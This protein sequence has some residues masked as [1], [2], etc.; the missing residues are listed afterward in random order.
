VD[1]NV[2]KNRWIVQSFDLSAGTGLFSSMN[3]SVFQAEKDFNMQEL[4]PNR[5]WTSVLGAKLEFPEG[6]SLNIEGYYKY[7]FDRL[8]VPIHF[9][10]N[11]IPTIQPY[12][13][14]VGRVWGIDAMIQK[15]Q[16]RYWDGWLSYSFSWAQYRD[17]NG[18][19]SEMGISRGTRGTDWYFPSYHRFHNLSLVVN[20]KPTPR[21]N[22]YARF[23]LASGVQISRR[24]GDGPESYPVYVYD[25]DD[26]AAS[27][28]I[29]KY[30]WPSVQ[31]EN[32]RTTPSLP[33]D[34]KLS[35][36]GKNPGG[37]AR[38][39]VYVAVENMLALLYNAEGNTSYNAYTG[40]VDTGSNSASY[41]IPIPVPSFG[42][43]FTY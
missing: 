23:G 17:P 7:I 6:L 42:F 5:S 24:V 40:E 37:K 8:Y 2:F 13:N 39:E 25:P 16:S 15:L 26:P 18:G 19:F 28:F 35:I 3:T 33:M 20:V 30:R 34:I 36:F 9:D 11:G 32:N 4:K 14:G 38:Y 43:K 41:E 29:E 1:F 10:I 27:R 31:D 21:I 22:I 12:F